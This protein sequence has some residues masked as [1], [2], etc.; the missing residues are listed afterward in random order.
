MPWKR[1][2]WRYF[3][4]CHVIVFRRGC[5]A[6]KPCLTKWTSGGGQSSSGQLAF[7]CRNL[8]EVRLCSFS[9]L[10]VSFSVGEGDLNLAAGAELVLLAKVMQGGRPVVGANVTAFVT[11]WVWRMPELKLLW[12]LFNSAI[13]DRD[14]V[15]EQEREVVLQDNGLGADRVAGDGLYSKYFIDFAANQVKLQLMNPARAEHF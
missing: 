11:R 14:V 6:E 7:G 4:E 9:K 8:D 12:K 2:A 5:Y 15:G 1:S 13:F 3:E 10:R